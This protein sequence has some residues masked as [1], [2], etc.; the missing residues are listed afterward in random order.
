VEI[1]QY[2]PLY[3]SLWQIW[4]L[5]GK[6]CDQKNKITL[7]A[8][9]IL[10]KFYF[11]KYPFT[12]LHNVFCTGF[13][14]TVLHILNSCHFNDT[15]FMPKITLVIIS[16]YPEIYLLL[17]L[18]RIIFIVKNWIQRIV[19]IFSKMKKHAWMEYPLPWFKFKKIYL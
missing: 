17:R 18:F 6:A 12:L 5:A 10:S 3:L 8:F 2:C 1:V 9:F 7:P 19:S 4:P 15:T 14:D 13:S 16:A 11:P